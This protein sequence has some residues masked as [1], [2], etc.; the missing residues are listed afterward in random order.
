MLKVVFGSFS[1]VH[2]ALILEKAKRRLSTQRGSSAFQGGCL[3]S[4]QKQ[5]FTPGYQTLN[6]Y[7]NSHPPTINHSLNDRNRARHR[8][9]GIEGDRVSYG[10]Q[11]IRQGCRPGRQAAGVSVACCQD[12]H[13]EHGKKR[14]RAWS[15][16]G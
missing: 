7:Q 9:C 14:R 4:L 8:A 12:D 10:F 15:A 3:E 2:H 6:I 1:E 5:T 13:R 11:A 16:R